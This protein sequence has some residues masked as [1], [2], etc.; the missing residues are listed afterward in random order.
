VAAL[1]A[2]PAAR[3]EVRQR[4][5][6]RLRELITEAFHLGLSERDFE[7]LVRELLRSGRGTR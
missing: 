4:L 3:H 7:S 1:R 6:G 5:T 2:Q